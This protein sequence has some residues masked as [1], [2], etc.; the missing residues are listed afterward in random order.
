MKKKNLEPPDAPPPKMPI[1]ELSDTMQKHMQRIA[2]PDPNLQTSKQAPESLF[3]SPSPQPIPVIASAESSSNTVTHSTNS[4]ASILASA[5]TTSKL[6]KKDQK[7]LSPSLQSLTSQPPPTSQP[8]PSMSLSRQGVQIAYPPPPHAKERLPSQIEEIQKSFIRQQQT[9]REAR[10][11]ADQQQKHSPKELKSPTGS[12]AGVAK[13]PD[14]PLSGG[15]DEA[16]KQVFFNERI[17]IHPSQLLRKKWS[18][19]TPGQSPTTPKSP[20]TLMSPKSAGGHSVFT[21]PQPSTDV[22]SF[23]HHAEVIREQSMQLLQ[24]QQATKSSPVTSGAATGKTK[25][26]LPHQH[27]K[28]MPPPLSP[29]SVSSLL[30]TTKTS[31]VIA[32]GHP[33]LTTADIPPPVNKEGVKMMSPTDHH[34][35]IELKKS[36]LKA[37]KREEKEKQLDEK[38]RQREL[39]RQK[40]REEKTK[41]KLLKEQRKAEKIQQ[42]VLKQKAMQAKAQA[43]KL[44]KKQK[45]ITTHVPKVAMPDK[46]QQPTLSTP[47]APFV[48]K[49][50]AVTPKIPLCEPDAQLVYPLV[51]PLGYTHCD[52]PITL[53]GVFGA[54]ILECVE[55]PYTEKPAVEEQLPTPTLLNGAPLFASPDRAMCGME[56]DDPDPGKITSSD[57]HTVVLQATENNSQEQ[58]TVN[59]NF[60]SE[61]QF[62]LDHGMKDAPPDDFDKVALCNNCYERLNETVYYVDKKLDEVSEGLFDRTDCVLT[63]QL[64]FCSNDCVE[65]YQH[66]VEYD[67][68]N[69]DFELIDAV[70]TAAMVTLDVTHVFAPLPTDDTRGDVVASGMDPAKLDSQKEEIVNARWKRWNYPFITTKKTRPRLERQDLY[71]LMNKYDV[72]LKPCD[73]IKDR[74]VCMLCNTTGDGETAQASRLLNYDVDQ[75]VHLNCALWSSEVYEA[76]NGGL[77]NVNKAFARSKNSLCSQ[78]NRPGATVNCT[79]T[80][81]VQQRQ[82]CEKNYHFCCAV[83]AQCSFYKDKVWMDGLVKEQRVNKSCPLVLGVFHVSIL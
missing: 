7:L 66:K 12:T 20:D 19:T 15:I 73:G 31:S 33:Q 74:R 54:G 65:V 83:Q 78:C 27:Q 2:Q 35:E 48:P 82:H 47:H 16:R 80:F 38:R 60:P 14:Q 8:S 6:T 44:T 62:E 64:A 70:K 50:P 34:K 22:R 51:Q 32:T 42:K 52:K 75:W 79:H 11:A 45:V 41:L 61:C 36:L 4:I 18:S 17:P 25:V 23:A 29:F 39:E 71:E 28:G 49:P 13:Q 46:Q 68:E 10:I 53:P 77:H 67:L 76:L 26:E 37:K 9:V 3:S 40:K 5:S 55:D 69:N 63:D 24:Q 58:P 56:F 59:A 30:G 57:E 43:L 81:G 21:S 1:P 72:R